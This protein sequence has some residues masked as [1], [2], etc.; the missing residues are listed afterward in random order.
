MF[1]RT[2]MVPSPD[3]SVLYTSFLVCQERVSPQRSRRG[4]TRSASGMR[5]RG[6][7]ESAS[8]YAR[9]AIAATPVFS[10]SRYFDV[11][12]SADDTFDKID[13]EELNTGVAAMAALAYALAD[14]EAPLERIPEAERVVPRRER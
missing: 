9:A 3:D 12:H 5:S 7:S 10:S 11:H 13:R 1:R 14:S 2:D 6:A 8:A 4:T